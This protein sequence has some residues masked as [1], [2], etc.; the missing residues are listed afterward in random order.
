MLKRF[1]T[2]L[3]NNCILAT[4]AFVALSVILSIIFASAAESEYISASADTF[5][6]TIIIDAG[7]GGEDS[8][9]VGVNGA[10]E[11]D[12]NLTVANTLGTYLEKAGFAVIYT[13]TEDKLLYTEAQNIKGMR[14]I[15]DLKNRVAVAKEYPDAL[16]V[17]IHMNS[18]AESKYSGLQ[19]YYSQTNPQSATLAN[20]VQTEVKSRLQPDN[21][22]VTKPGKD[23]YILENIENTGI[24]IECGFLSNPEECKKLSEKEYQKE[25]C[26][27]ILCGII[28]YTDKKFP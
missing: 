26:F 13:R 14:K 9:T 5:I 15:H 23:L 17:S 16:F 4:A 27:S 18:F 11:K 28:N 8:G 24:L 2:F 21:N 22:R 7:H 25:L 10:Y 6:R 3:K 12:I 1:S 20:S 19:V